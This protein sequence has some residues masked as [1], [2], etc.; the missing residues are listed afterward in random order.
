[1]CPPLDAITNS[2]FLKFQR[3]A[4]AP[5]AA[6]TRDN[7]TGTKGSLSPLHPFITGTTFS[8][9]HPLCHHAIVPF[10]RVPHFSCRPIAKATRG[11]H[12]CISQ[13]GGRACGG[14]VVVEVEARG[15]QAQGLRRLAADHIVA[16]PVHVV[17]AGRCLYLVPAPPPLSSF[18]VPPGSHSYASFETPLRTCLAVAGAQKPAHG[19]TS[20]TRARCPYTS[21]AM[22]S[23][24]TSDLVPIG[25]VAIQLL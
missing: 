16:L 11:H 18:T 4:S 17:P 21:V 9:P 8:P 6:G 15:T 22:T 12:R 3:T 19:E 7:K 2:S 14:V 23:I 13:L 5:S 24:S 10:R 1:M 25:T 20:R